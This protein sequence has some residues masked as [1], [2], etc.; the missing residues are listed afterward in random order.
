MQGRCGFDAMSV[1]ARTALWHRT[2]FTQFYAPYQTQLFI[3]HTDSETAAS[4][5][6]WTLPW[7]SEL[8]VVRSAKHRV[9]RMFEGMLTGDDLWHCR[10]YVPQSS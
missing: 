1:Q 7:T 5:N 9:E 3:H 4:S 6:S 2:S 10:I 8:Q